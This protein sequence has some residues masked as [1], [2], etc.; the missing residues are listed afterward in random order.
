[1][2]PRFT[3]DADGEIIL[4]KG[5]KLKPNTVYMEAFT[6][7]P[8]AFQVNADFLVNWITRCVLGDLRTLWAGITVYHDDEARR[9]AEWLGGGNYLLGAGCCMALEYFARIFWGQDNAQA[10]VRE[11]SKRFLEGHR[12]AEV[13]DLFW[14]IFRNG[15]IH[16][17]GPQVPFLPEA[18]T[19]PVDVG[20]GYGIK[21]AHLGP[22]PER[23]SFVLDAKQFLADLESSVAGDNGFAQ[24]LRTQGPE[25]LKRGAPRRLDLTKEQ[26]KILR[27]V[28]A[29]DR[30]QKPS[31]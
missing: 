12:Y 13:C 6:T 25:V 22:L 9:H 21:D 24:W 5:K 8:P 1:M 27:R 10:N 30:K 3:T 23:E 7:P 15:L 26:A 31:G 4:K 28:I 19:K 2:A 17:S 11:Y 18:P 14:P 16:S 29:R 20:V